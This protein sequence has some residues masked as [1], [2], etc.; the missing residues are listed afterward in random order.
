MSEHAPIAPELETAPPQ[1]L[2]RRAKIL[3][4]GAAALG[5]LSAL[6][7]SQWGSD[8]E[9]PSSRQT[10]RIESASKGQH[11]GL[12]VDVVRPAKGGLSRKIVTTGSVEAFETA[13]LFARVS[14]TL[15]SI[16]VDIGDV[17]TEGQVLAEIDAPELA[18][19][20]QWKQALHEQAQSRVLQ[21][22]ARVKTAQV[23]R[24]AA[25]GLVKQAE[26]EVERRTAERR[27]SEKEL[28]R[29]GE[30]VAQKAIES[31]LLAEKQYRFEA[32]KAGEDHA[33]AAAEVAQAEIQTID[34]RIEEAKADL[35]VAEADVRVAEADLA[36][37]QVMA[38]YAKIVA[39]FSGRI[40]Q[41]NWDAGAY[42]P[43][44]SPSGGGTPLVVLA[45]TDRMR[46]VF[47]VADPD[48]P[49]VQ[50]GQQASVSIDALGGE[51]FQGHVSRISHHQDSKTRTMRAEIDLPNAEG[52]LTSGMYAAATVS[53]P[54]SPESVLIPRD[55]LV[56]QTRGGRGQVYVL[57][58]GQVQLRTVGLGASDEKR[59]EV[60]W[61]LRPDELLLANGSDDRPDLHEGA[62]ATIAA[63]HET[64]SVLINDAE[65]T[66]QASR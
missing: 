43:S 65:S 24:L 63:I 27:L 60:L 31:K 56:G 12:S 10:G 5:S 36:R 49:I 18:K 28:A 22:Q 42:V 62:I 38:D 14:G 61:N 55:C 66:L 58:E 44:A 15:K 51:T 57:T 21:A 23:E 2:R 6:W 35:R 17:V 48:V 33:R 41:R 50:I 54:P 53:A 32:A 64:P 25:L 26:A 3:I 11:S 7:A 39:P 4:A 40:I 13:E 9:W 47:R 46:V 52:K 45:K 8:G 37:A 34:S 30:L 19:D 16:A 29:I 59:V 1:N 20:V